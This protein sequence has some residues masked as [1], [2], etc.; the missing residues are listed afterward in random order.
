M[1]MRIQ[2]PRFYSLS[3]FQYRIVR[4]RL[5]VLLLWFGLFSMS[6]Q[7][8]VNPNINIDSPI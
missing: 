2:D 1:L 5:A 4:M 3:N 6:V 8:E 7:S